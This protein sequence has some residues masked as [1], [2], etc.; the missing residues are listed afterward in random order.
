MLR[1]SW[2]IPWS[3]TV[4]VVGLIK[5]TIGQLIVGVIWRARGCDLVLWGRYIGSGIERIRS[6]YLLLRQSQSPG[7]SNTQETWHTHN[8]I[9][10][11]R[12]H[13]NPLAFTDFVCR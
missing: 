2:N 1:A 6:T 9:I 5:S 8:G 12:K 7:G 10:E 11:K 13:W 4:G 3:V